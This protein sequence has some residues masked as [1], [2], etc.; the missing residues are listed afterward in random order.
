MDAV[1][2]PEH[3]EL[4]RLDKRT[5]ELLIASAPLM[6]QWAESECKPKV[7]GGM[8]E[9]AKKHKHEEVHTDEGCG[10][11]HSTWQYLRLLNMVAVPPWYKF[12]NRALSGILRKKP[13]ARVLISACADWGMLATL[14]EAIETAGAKPHVMIYDICRT[15]LLACQWYAERHGLDIDCVCDNILTSPK[16]PLHSFDLIVTDEFLTVLKAEYKP[17]ILTRWNELLAPGGSVVTTAMLGGPTNQ[18]LRDNYA[19]RAR[20][21]LGEHAEDFRQMAADPADIVSRFERFAQLHNRHMLKDEAEIRTLFS[22]FYLGFMSLTP[23]PG[24]CVNPTDSFQ[25]VAAVPHTGR[26]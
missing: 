10:W 4:Y 16:M 24:E 12:Y 11:Y 26:P 6:A 17:Q 25:I 14:H 1:A 5:H 9:W 22:D 2:T 21:R 20:Q 15:P 19:A 7:V 8:E 23:T 18:A 13:N 3:D